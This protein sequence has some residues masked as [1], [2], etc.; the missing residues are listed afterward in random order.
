MRIYGLRSRSTIGDGGG[1]ARRIIQKKCCGPKESWMKRNKDFLDE[2][3]SRRSVGKFAVSRKR[4]LLHAD[5]VEHGVTLHHNCEYLVSL[6]RCFGRHLSLSPCCNRTA[7]YT[8]ARRAQ[9]VAIGTSNIHG[10]CGSSC[11]ASLCTGPVTLLKTQPQ[12]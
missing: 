5:F 12:T 8:A 11:E 2:K 3:M 1:A 7:E 4:H 10:K 6:V 9:S